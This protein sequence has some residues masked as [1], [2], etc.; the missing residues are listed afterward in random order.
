M[1]FFHSKAE[2]IG[3]SVL[4]LFAISPYIT[5][6]LL[7]RQPDPLVTDF[8]TQYNKHGEQFKPVT[9]QI[10][11]DMGIGHAMVVLKKESNDE[12]L[13]FQANQS[14][15]VW[16]YD[17]K[18]LKHNEKPITQKFEPYDDQYYAQKLVAANDIANYLSTYSLLALGVWFCYTGLRGRVNLSLLKKA[19]QP[20]PK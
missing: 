5:E 2:K 8:L 12:K 10:V 18:F 16:F 4:S 3:V 6:S 17:Q 15:F 1:K 9:Q 20:P 11:R 19:T 14:H 7:K 13:E